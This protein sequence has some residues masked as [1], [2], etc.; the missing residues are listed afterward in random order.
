MGEGDRGKC[1]GI[2]RR[3]QLEMGEEREKLRKAR[4]R[5]SAGGGEHEEGKEKEREPEE[6]SESG[7]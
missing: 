3:G 7:R 2:K 4:G 1:V 5:N 6:G